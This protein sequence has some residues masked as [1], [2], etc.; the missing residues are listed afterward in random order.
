MPVELA[1]VQKG[2]RR[3]DDLFQR[4]G[5]VQFQKRDTQVDRSGNRRRFHTALGGYAMGV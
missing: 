1:G 3:R 2:Q 4:F 5:A